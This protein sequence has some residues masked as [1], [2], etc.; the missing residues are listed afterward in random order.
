MTRAAD[1]LY[2][3]TVRGQESPFIRE[4][5]GKIEPVEKIA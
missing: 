3:V 2:L 4:L 1:L 5:A